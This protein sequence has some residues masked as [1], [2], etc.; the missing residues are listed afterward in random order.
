MDN[1]GLIGA[2]DHLPWRLPDDMKH[3]KAV[4]MGK[5][6]VMGRKTYETIP[7]R[8]RPLVGR[9]NI[10]LTAQKDFHAPGCI[11]AHSI[12]QALG[13]AGAVQEVMVIGGASIYEQFLPLAD[14]IYL[15]LIDGEFEGDVYFPPFNRQEWFEVEKTIHQADEK[16]TH[17]FTIFLL[18]RRNIW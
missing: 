9:T 10:I 2:G 7:D 16:H 12:E 15:T 11:V 14:C 6:V 18:E 1:N 3:F 5:P 13:A 17:P 8:F 4:T